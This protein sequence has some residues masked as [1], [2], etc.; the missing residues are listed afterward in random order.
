M[1]R[2]RKA[3]L[4]INWSLAIVAA[5]PTVPAAISAYSAYRAERTSRETH[6]IVNSRM[7]ELLTIN[8]AQSRQEGVIEGE[9]RERDQT[10]K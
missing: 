6:K 8:R 9:R 2:V 1:V 7:D 3:P 4:R 10:D 5:I